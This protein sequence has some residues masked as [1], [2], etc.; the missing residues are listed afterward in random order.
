VPLAGRR[1][2]AA[3]QAGRPLDAEDDRLPIA[4]SRVPRFPH[5]RD[6][7]DLVVEGEPEEVAKRKIG[8][9]PPAL[10]AP[11]ALKALHGLSNAAKQADIPETTLYLIELRASQ[12]NGCGVC[13]DMHSRGLKHAGDPDP[14]I[15]TEHHR[16]NKD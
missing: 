4:A 5:A 6:E 9:H 12:I 14:R 8:I 13:V 3:D 11:G 15:L 1:F 10:T 16:T 7:K 2:C